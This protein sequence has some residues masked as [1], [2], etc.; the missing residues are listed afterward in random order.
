MRCEIAVT[1]RPGGDLGC[2][3]GTAP[4]LKV[5]E[6]SP[7]ALLSGTSFSESRKVLSVATQF[8]FTPNETL[9]LEGHPANFLILIESGKIKLTRTCGDGND[10]T[11]RICRSGEI[12]DM[13]A[14][15]G[16]SHHTCSARAVT[17]CRVLIWD[18]KQALA[19]GILYPQIRANL[20]RI[21]A[22]LLAELEERFREIAAENCGQRLARTLLTLVEP[23]GRA[24]RDGTRVVLSRSELAQMT[25][26]TALAISRTLSKWADAGI[27]GRARD[28]IVIHR[29]SELR[30]L[31]ERDV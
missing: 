7:S 14:E 18:S 26:V 29:P 21:S 16:Y 4:S 17:T 20:K 19:M 2:I 11:L 25:G 8:S 30:T 15:N 31:R 13:Y 23:I 10:I 5:N 12:V 24:N 28:A 3:N 22:N 9:F 27:I 1:V 6:M